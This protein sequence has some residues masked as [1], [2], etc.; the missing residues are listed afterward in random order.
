M[1]K[2]RR[3]GADDSSAGIH[4]A[5]WGSEIEGS[6][7][8]DCVSRE[9]VCEFFFFFPLLEGRVIGGSVSGEVPHLVAYVQKRSASRSRRLEQTL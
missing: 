3:G 4:A 8:D 5:R 9:H 2:R 6:A 1:I 7:S